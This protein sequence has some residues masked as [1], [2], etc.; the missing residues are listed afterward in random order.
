MSYKIKGFA[1]D[2]PEELKNVS[3]QNLRRGLNSQDLAVI[4][5]CFVEK[6]VECYKNCKDVPGLVLVVVNIQG[7]AVFYTMTQNAPAS[8]LNE[9]IDKAFTSLAKSADRY[10]MTTRMVYT[11]AMTRKP[12][13]TDPEHQEISCLKEVNTLMNQQSSITEPPEGYTL[14]SK[15]RHGTEFYNNTLIPGGVPLFSHNFLIGAIGVAGGGNIENLDELVAEYV[16]KD[17]RLDP[18][19]GAER[20]EFRGVSPSRQ[21]VGKYRTPYCDEEPARY[22]PTK[23]EWFEGGF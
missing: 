7:L 19:E 10:E 4:K 9:A 23:G 13:G 5:K 11:Q 8:A 3:S 16:S 12:G 2:L 20:H 15:S 6:V 1:K 14:Y 21:Q 22:K 17:Y 18:I